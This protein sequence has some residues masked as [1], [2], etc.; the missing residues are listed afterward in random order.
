VNSSFLLSC[1]TVNNYS[2]K[3]ITSSQQIDQVT[4]TSI[5]VV[6]FN[7]R[8]KTKPAAK[9][10]S[11]GFPLGQLAQTAVIQEQKTG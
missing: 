1:N 10:N 11:K 6:L 5:E 7:R 4:E 9:I 2:N 3:V 8:Q